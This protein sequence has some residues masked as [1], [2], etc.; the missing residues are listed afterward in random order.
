MAEREAIANAKSNGTINKMANVIQGV[1]FGTAVMGGA[2]LE[3]LFAGSARTV[4]QLFRENANRWAIAAAEKLAGGVAVSAERRVLQHALEKG[5]QDFVDVDLSQ[6]QK[7]AVKLPTT[8]QSAQM[9]VNVQ[10]LANNPSA[11]NNAAV[12]TAQNM[13]AV[14]PQMAQQVQDSF[15]EGVRTLAGFVPTA[16]QRMKY[17][18]AT[19]EFDP[20][21]LKRFAIALRAVTDPASVAQ[22]LARGQLSPTA[23]EAL[24]KA[25]PELAI[26][27]QDQ[28]RAS[29]ALAR[30]TKGKK[31]HW[32]P[33]KETAMAGILKD[34]DL[35][36]LKPKTIKLNQA[37]YMQ[38][39]GE[40]SGGAPAAGGGAGPMA[41]GQGAAARMGGASFAK[42]Y[43]TGP[44]KT[45]FGGF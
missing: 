6:A 26:N 15:K 21:E 14:S 2:G 19:P 12:Q 36:S 42:A 31:F 16:Y 43:A 40:G 9:A 10:N 1:V 20:Y 27:M 7:A 44:Q 13:G 8:A 22:D 25:N 17:S 37:T 39:S 38:L 5:F 23:W 11:L 24:Q 45:A 18:D 32:T 41:G 34:A 3:T 30:G 29:I 4:G 28:L 35:P 33:Q